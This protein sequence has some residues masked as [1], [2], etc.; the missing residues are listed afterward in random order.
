ML[1]LLLAFAA[2]PAPSDYF[3]F[4]HWTLTLPTGGEKRPDVISS[5]RLQGGYASAYF[6]AEPA[7]QRMI[8]W[9]PVDGVTTAHTHYPRCELR[10]Q[11]HGP[12]DDNATWRMGDF[13]RSE[14]DATCV[15]ERVGPDTGRVIVGQIH[16]VDFPL[17]KLVYA[18]NRRLGTGQLIA[19][20]NRD[21][22]FHDHPSDYP[23][24]LDVPLGQP[25][26]YVIRVVA[27]PGRAEV[28]VTIPGA[29]PASCHVD[30]SAWLAHP[31]KG[32][33]FKAGDYCN[34]RGASATEGALVGFSALRAVHVAGTNL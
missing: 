5:A 2:A 10:E 22:P 4:S 15:V 26:S 13:G 27:R 24:A 25:F 11:I 34:D 6:Y 9:C 18:W 20:I 30:E 23:L 32:L 3:D 19:Q 8:F 21:D 1:G 31:R 7:T 12:A 14:L 29:V 16:A 33:Y 17:L 28:S